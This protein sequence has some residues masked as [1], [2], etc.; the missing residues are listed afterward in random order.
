MEAW[1]GFCLVDGKWVSD[2]GGHEA[3]ENN[4]RQYDGLMVFENRLG[5]TQELFLSRYA[6]K[7]T[8]S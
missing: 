4:T 1:R 5:L 2:I 8:A 7:M 6:T 3:G